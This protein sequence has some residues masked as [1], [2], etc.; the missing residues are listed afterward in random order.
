VV[1]YVYITHFVI[2]SLFKISHKL[3]IQV[4]KKLMHVDGHIF[5]DFKKECSTL[6]QPTNGQMTTNCDRQISG[7]E[8]TFTCDEGYTLD[9]P[10]LL[11]CQDNGTWGPTNH[12]PECK[13][14]KS[15]IYTLHKVFKI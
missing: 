8:L 2:I 14:R 10:S 6:T 13:I 7:C 9:G 1:V 4:L 11:T 12:P 3:K 5:S 15:K